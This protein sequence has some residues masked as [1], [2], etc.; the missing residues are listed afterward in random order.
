MQPA[1]TIHRRRPPLSGSALVLAGFFGLAVTGCRAPATAPTAPAS[2][3][4]YD[5][6]LRNGTIYDGSG[7]PPI[8]GDVA[9]RGDT[10]V[11]VGHVDPA[12]ARTELDAIGLAIAPG[13]INMLSW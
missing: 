7:Q 2:P 10:I 9:I 4:T 6:L 8:R 3:M 11:A 1:S 12:R 13:F 5:V